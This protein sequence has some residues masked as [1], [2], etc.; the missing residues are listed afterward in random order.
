MKKQRMPLQ[1]GKPLLQLRCLFL[2]LE[3]YYANS[4]LDLVHRSKALAEWGKLAKGENVA[5][6]RALGAFDLFVLHDQSGDLLEV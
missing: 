6:E 5:L 3:R 4:V 2:T 1:E